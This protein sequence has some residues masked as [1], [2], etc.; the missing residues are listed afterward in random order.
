MPVNIHLTKNYTDQ[1]NCKISGSIVHQ[2]AFIEELTKDSTDAYIDL[3][4]KLNGFYYIIYQADNLLYAS[5]DHIRSNPLF[6]ALIDDTLY[7]S[8]SAEWIRKELKIEEMDSLFKQEFLH[9]GFVTGSDTL[10]AE[11][12]QLRA[13]ESLK[14]ENGKLELIRH[15][16]YVHHEPQVYSEELLSKELYNALKKSFNNLVNYANGRQIVIPLSGGYDSR[17]VAIMLKEIGY[18]NIVTFTYGI[19]DNKEAQYSKI[20]ADALGLDWFFVEYTPEL[21]Q[22]AWASSVRYEYQVMASNGVSLPHVQDWLAVKLIREQK[23]VDDA[24]FVPGHGGDFLAGCDIPTFVVEKEITYTKNELLNEILAYYYTLSPI[25]NNTD[26]NHFT[27][28]IANM[29]PINLERLSAID[30]ADQYEKWVWQE[31]ESKFI[32]NSVRVYEFF[33][34][35]WWMP[36]CDKELFNY[37]STLP[38]NLRNH[39][40]YQDYVSN[41]FSK[42]Y[43]NS[44]TNASDMGSILNKLR[45]FALKDTWCANQL[46]KIYRTLFKKGNLATSSRYP[47]VEYQQLINK[48]YSRNGI[49][50]YFFIQD[51]ERKSSCEK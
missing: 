5:V 27:Q 48:G 18:E 10:Y 19:K 49:A 30:Y 31:Q 6:Y 46:K 14:F 37:F 22:K 28:R 7:L 32:C 45:A 23:L 15:Y 40:W 36:L 21:W 29:G 43:K 39:R 25:E 2:E 26:R 13:G 8:D 50:A 44:L 33:N 47:Q 42:Y 12:K 17:L 24:I 11:I 20:V 34:Y 9:T 3:I 38:L 41:L 16:E 35:D 51:M 1:Y 4:S